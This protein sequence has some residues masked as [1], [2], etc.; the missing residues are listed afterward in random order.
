M[1]LYEVKRLIQDDE[2]GR[3]AVWKDQ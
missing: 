1:Y 3:W 2:S